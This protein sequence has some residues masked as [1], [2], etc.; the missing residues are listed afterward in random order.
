MSSAFYKHL[1]LIFLVISKSFTWNPEKKK[2]MNRDLDTQKI[3][4][5]HF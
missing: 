2:D 5:I 1:L 3:I 4:K